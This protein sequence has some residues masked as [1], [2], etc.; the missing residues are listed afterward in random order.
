M[1]SKKNKH[2]SIINIG[3]SVF[4]IIVVLFTG[5]SVHSQDFSLGFSQ[6]MVVNGES[7]EGDIVCTDQDATKSCTEPYLSNMVGVVTDSPSILLDDQNLFGAKPVLTSGLAKVRISTAN[8]NIK[9]GDF[10]TTSDK[11]GVGQKALKSGYVLGVAQQD[12]DADGIIDVQVSIRLAV[13]TST[14]R[15]NLLDTAKDALLAP[16]LTP[17][18]S[19]RYILA[20]IA[21]GGAFILGFMYFG[22]VARSGVEAIG[23]NP[24]AGRMIQFSVILNL[25]LTLV[26]MGSGLLIAYLILVL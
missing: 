26:I 9:K 1:I 7:V 19:L 6:S 20:A 13:V 5:N 15:T 22:R 18:A 4:I 24:L 23:R 21:A 8:G 25:L 10:I 11:P 12:A 2:Y 14:Q 17:L 3:L 16:Y